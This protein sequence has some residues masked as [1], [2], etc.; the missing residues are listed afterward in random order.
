[1]INFST[2][3]SL[4]MSF[5]QQL[6]SSSLAW[7]NTQE[8]VR[9]KSNLLAIIEIVDSVLLQRLLRR[10]DRG[11]PKYH[12]EISIAFTDMSVNPFILI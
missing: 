11:G 12:Q 1:M 8:L 10:G 6:F 2:P 5:D 9:V 7:V 4:P 3:L